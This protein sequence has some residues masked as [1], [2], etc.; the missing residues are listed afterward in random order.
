[1]MG[2][3]IAT[4]LTLSAIG[5]FMWAYPSK[6][7]RRS[8]EMRVQAMGVGLTLIS[9]SVPDTSER[10][11]IEQHSRRVTGYKLRAPAVAD[12]PRFMALRSTAECGYGL[13]EGWVWETPS[14]RAPT[15]LRQ[16]LHRV[17][18]KMPA[19]VELIGVLP[20]GLVVAIDESRRAAA[21]V[22]TLHATL[23]D[24]SEQLSGTTT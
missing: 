20:D 19:W 5:S 8:A 16:A 22:E 15:E 10:G 24:A 21:D 9:L 11:R 13:P 17:L 2:L 14:F 3:A 7:D 6:V 23:L 4:L 18:G 12:L 1:M